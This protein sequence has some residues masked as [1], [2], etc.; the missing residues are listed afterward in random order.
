[1]HG[2]REPAAPA[3]GRAQGRQQGMAH[4]TAGCQ[5]AAPTVCQKGG[6]REGPEGGGGV[7]RRR[8]RHKCGGD[9]KAE[10]ARRRAR[11]MSERGPAERG[12]ANRRVTYRRGYD[13]EGGRSSMHERCGA[14]VVGRCREGC[15]NNWVAVRLPLGAACEAGAA[16]MRAPAPGRRRAGTLIPCPGRR[17][18]GAAGSADGAAAVAVAAAAAL[19]HC[20]ARQLGEDGLKLAH[21]VG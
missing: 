2:R 18:D 20:G 4:R 6:G 19:D 9:C 16:C 17:C 11:R 3:N 5:G 12:R 10:E 15:V 14:A 1:M 21:L 7:G 8:G 13:G